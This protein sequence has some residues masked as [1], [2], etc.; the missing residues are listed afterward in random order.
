MSSK[1]KTLSTILNIGAIVT[2][3]IAVINFIMGIVGIKAFFD[4]IA[5]QAYDFND[6]ITLLRVNPTIYHDYILPIFTAIAVYGGIALILFGMAHRLK[7]MAMEDIAFENELDG[8]DYSEYTPA[9]EDE[10]T[11]FE[12]ALEEVTEEAVEENKE[13]AAE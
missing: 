8:V 13:E 9:F 10:N 3:V 7:L 6:V 12:E 5:E 11:S 1:T 4:A 2:T